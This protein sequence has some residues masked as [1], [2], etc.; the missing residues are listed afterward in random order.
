[1]NWVLFWNALC[2]AASLAVSHSILRYSAQLDSSLFQLPR[3]AYV[4]AALVIYLGIFIYYSHLLERIPI[5]RLYP[6][7]TALSIVLV[8]VSGV[9]V[10]REDVTMRGLIGTLIIVGGVAL[11]AG[12]SSA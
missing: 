4:A 2:L 11:V 8:Y 9:L 6:I 12:E 10:F 5:S 1:M 7:Y 3:L